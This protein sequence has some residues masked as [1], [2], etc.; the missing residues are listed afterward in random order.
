MLPNTSLTTH[1]N[2]FQ[3]LNSIVFT[4]FRDVPR[5][6][7][8]LLFVSFSIFVAK[9]KIYQPRPIYTNQEFPY[10]PKYSN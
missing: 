9:Q 7:V 5:G 10:M 8:G 2:V 1:K 3:N 4:I 6:R